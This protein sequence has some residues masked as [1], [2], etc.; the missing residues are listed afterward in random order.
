VPAPERQV[1]IQSEGAEDGFVQIS[2]ADRGSGFSVNNSAE[3]FEAFHTTKPDGLGLGLV[4]CRSIIE[5][6]GG[7]LLVSNNNGRG[8][9][10][11]FTVRTE[12][13]TTA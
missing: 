3:M 2:V 8:A 1:T 13:G 7:Q 6:H 4:I 9:T 5:S 11:R 12:K 10:V